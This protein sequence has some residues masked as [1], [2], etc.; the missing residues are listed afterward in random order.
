MYLYGCSILLT[1]PLCALCERKFELYIWS[2]KSVDS[3]RD[4]ELLALWKTTDTATGSP[5]GTST[6]RTQLEFLVQNQN[7]SKQVWG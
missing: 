7:V 3:C 4:V 6:Q 2:G 1:P 5:L